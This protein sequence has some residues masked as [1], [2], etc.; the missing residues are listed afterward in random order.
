MNR[1]T[2]PDYVNQ[3][4]VIYKIIKIRSATVFGSVGVC[5]CAC[6]PVWNVRDS[7]PKNRRQLF[8][9]LLR[10]NQM[11]NRKKVPLQ[12]MRLIEHRGPEEISHLIYPH[13]N[14]DL[15]W[16]QSFFFLKIHSYNSLR[17]WWA[18]WRFLLMV[19]LEGI[20]LELLAPK[21]VWIGSNDEKLNFCLIKIFIMFLGNGYSN[22]TVDITT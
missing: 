11:R 22:S 15:K 21:W 10:K 7:N 14:F 16:T 4:K 3:T 6:I 2:F 20:F 17:R 19:A 9:F 5:V 1:Q 18:F 12:E 8:G 13:L